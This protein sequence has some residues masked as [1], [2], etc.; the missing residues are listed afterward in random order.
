[1]KK[2]ILRFAFL[3]YSYFI[4]IVHTL[5][6][7]LPPV[8]RVPIW[9]VIL[10]E[11]GARVFIDGKVY[12]RYPSTAFLG[13]DVSINRGCEFFSSWHNKEKT[14]IT[15]GNNVRIGP[16]VKFFAAGHDARDILLPDNSSSITIGD[17]V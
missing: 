14:R 1:M 5:V 4:D 13:S 17:N 16:R 11:M 10:G 3:H 6:F 2:N 8:I 15:I 9:K 7:I 12:F